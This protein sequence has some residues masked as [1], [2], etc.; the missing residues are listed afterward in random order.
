M[1]TDIF[2]GISFSPF[3]FAPI[4][5]L[6]S[7]AWGKDCGKVKSKGPKILLLSSKSSLGLGRE[8]NTKVW[9]TEQ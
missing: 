3:V 1:L 7:L 5:S 6:C 9:K 4:K 8:K 2:H